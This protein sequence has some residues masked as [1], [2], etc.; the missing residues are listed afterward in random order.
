MKKEVSLDD[1]EEIRHWKKHL[2]NSQMILLDT[3]FGVEKNKTLAIKY[4]EEHIFNT[5]KDNPFLDI[6]TFFVF[7]EKDNEQVPI[8]IFIATVSDHKDE[9]YVVHELIFNLSNHEM[10]EDFLSVINSKQGSLI[11]LSETN[12]VIAIF[13]NKKEREFN[14]HTINA[15]VND[16]LV[17][18]NINP[19]LFDEALQYIFE[20]GDAKE[21][22]DIFRENSPDKKI[23]IFTLEID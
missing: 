20:I 5:F 16:M 17:K 15:V 18:P 8:C 10:K 23:Q 4:T 14:S 19:A 21:I 2:F 13:D 11:L 6:D 1:I 12:S 22:R 7:I 3:R 9:N